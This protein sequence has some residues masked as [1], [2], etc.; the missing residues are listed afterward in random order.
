MPIAQNTQAA[1]ESPRE[2]AHI[3]GAMVGAWS[4]ERSLYEILRGPGAV[5]RY[6][7]LVQREPE[8]HELVEMAFATVG[9]HTRIM[10]LIE[11]LR[12]RSQQP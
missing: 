4:I 2:F 10:A 6:C 3:S 12:L 8:Q 7:A 1:T 11:E 9:A 5:D